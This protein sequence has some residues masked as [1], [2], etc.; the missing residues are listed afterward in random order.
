MF[1][2]ERMTIEYNC[3]KQKKSISFYVIFHISLS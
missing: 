2:T 1:F 3:I